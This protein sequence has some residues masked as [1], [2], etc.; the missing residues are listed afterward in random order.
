MLLVFRLPVRFYG[1]EHCVFR[2]VATLH[3]RLPVLRFRTLR[4]SECCCS[5]F[6]VACPSSFSYFIL[7]ISYFKASVFR[8][9]SS[10]FIFKKSLIIAC[11]LKTVRLWTSS[12]WHKKR[13]NLNKPSLFFVF[14]FVYPI[15][16]RLKP[17]TVNS[18]SMLCKNCRTVLLESLTN[19]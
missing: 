9:P 19:F 12:F 7:N 17:V 16:F 13:E 15:P 5:P 8:Y 18:L 2:N 3:L 10:G 11:G 6:A 4:F 14:L 1:S